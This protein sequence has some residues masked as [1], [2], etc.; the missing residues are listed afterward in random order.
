M[1]F[2][3]LPNEI[4][5]EIVEHLDKEQDINCLICVSR[6]FYYLFNDYLYCYN[7]KHRRC[8]ALFWATKHGRESTARNLLHLG[9]DVNATVEKA[10][11]YGN[12]PKADNASSFGGLGGASSHGE[13]V[14]GSR[15][16]SL[17]GPWISTLVFEEGFFGGRRKPPRTTADTMTMWIQT[18]IH[19][20][21]A[22]PY[23][24]CSTAATDLLGDDGRLPMCL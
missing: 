7:I 16:R 22:L 9:A 3:S 21:I 1:A 10:R 19:L 13:I 23:I 18:T 24:R 11:S 17:I 20:K 6:R 14:A 8:S 5:F 15:S 2:F 4:I 12:G